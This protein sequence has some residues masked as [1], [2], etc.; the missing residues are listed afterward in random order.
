LQQE[1]KELCCHCDELEHRLLKQE[2]L[3]TAELQ[4][5]FVRDQQNLNRI[6]ELEAAFN[7]LNQDLVASE[8]YRASLQRTC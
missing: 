2:E 5:A 3:K 1:L 8:S 7:H 6:A 4:Q